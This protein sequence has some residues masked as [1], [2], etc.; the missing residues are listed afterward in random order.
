MQASLNSFKFE[1]SGIMTSHLN[2]IKIKEHSAYLGKFELVCISLLVQR[3][4]DWLLSE[5]QYLCIIR[6]ES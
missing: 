6:S 4:D 3:A 1:E 5:I 2:V